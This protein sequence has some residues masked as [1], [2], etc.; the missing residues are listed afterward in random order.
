MAR[1]T[2]SQKEKQMVLE[3]YSDFLENH[4]DG[5]LDLLNQSHQSRT[6]EVLPLPLPRFLRQV[7]EKEYLRLVL[8]L[9]G[10]TFTLEEARVML[11][12]V[13]DLSDMDKEQEKLEKILMASRL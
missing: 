13:S 2:K 11:S 1:L 7:F 6:G 9:R 3:I 4:F 10:D 5:L 12:L 8:L